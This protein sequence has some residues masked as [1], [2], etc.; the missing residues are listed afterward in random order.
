MPL[1]KEKQLQD[2][3]RALSPLGERPQ[4]GVILGSGLGGFGDTLDSLVKLP[5]ADIPGMAPPTVAGHPGNFCSGRR[6]GVPIL[7]MQGRVHPY[8]GHSAEQVVFGACVLAACG[9]R[10]VLITNAAGGICEEFRPG[11]LMLITDH[12]NLTGQNPLVGPHDGRGA[13]FNDMSQAYDPELQ[14]AAIRVAAREQIALQ[15]GVYAG[16][17]GPTYETPAEV[18]MLSRLGASAVGMSTVLEVIALRQLGVRVGAVSCI[19]NLAAGLS[20]TPLS[21]AEVE[22]TAAATRERFT[23]LLTGWIGEIAA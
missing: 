23:A 2:A 21:H 6:G 3:A 10:S 12:L 4:L 1:P 8:E 5:Y 14:A 22:S 9:C 18:R 7:C 15:Q 20:S 17:M 11:D 16:L 19:T 13:R